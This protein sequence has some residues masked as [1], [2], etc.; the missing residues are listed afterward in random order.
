MSIKVNE[1]ISTRIGKLR[2][3]K[4]MKYG[5][6]NLRQSLIELSEFSDVDKIYVNRK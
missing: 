2:L 4:D 6:V 5:R 1:Y 3:M